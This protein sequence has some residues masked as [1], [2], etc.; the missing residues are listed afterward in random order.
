MLVGSDKR[1]KQDFL[2][3]PRKK[4]SGGESFFFISGEGGSVTQ[5]IE[6]RGA[7]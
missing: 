6:N 4:K 5:R 1:L 3:E 7:D 2:S